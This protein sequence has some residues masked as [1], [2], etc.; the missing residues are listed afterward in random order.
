MFRE[1]SWKCC[2]RASLCRCKP[3]FRGSGVYVPRSVDW[4]PA[5]RCIISLIPRNTDGSQVAPLTRE[6]PRRR[7]PPSTTLE[8]DA[9]MDQLFAPM[10]IPMKTGGAWTGRRRSTT[11]RGCC[12]AACA[13]L[14]RGVSRVRV[15]LSEWR[16]LRSDAYKSD[17]K[18]VCRPCI[19]CVPIHYKRIT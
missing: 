13:R 7:Y 2:L 8:T 9:F 19:D 3:N 15:S 5:S 1:Q 6:H 11:G 17:A 4:H 12:R 14:R 16:L 10:F 18:T